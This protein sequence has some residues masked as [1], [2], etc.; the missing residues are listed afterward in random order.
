MKQIGTL[1]TID[2]L[3]IGG[4]VFTD[5]TNLITLYAATN[6]VSTFATFRKNGSQVA[7]GYQVTSGK[8]LFIYAIQIQA[9]GAGGSEVAIAQTDTD[10]NLQSAGPLVSPIYFGTE[11]TIATPIIVGESG[12]GVVGITAGNPLGIA[13]SGKYLSTDSLGTTGCIVLAYG[14]EA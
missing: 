9:E 1:G 13:T 4:R 12:T 14:Y 6:A 11:S 5:L 3:T 10:V 2:T 7:A 8:T